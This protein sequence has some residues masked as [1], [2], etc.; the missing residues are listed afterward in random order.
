MWLGAYL[1]RKNEKKEKSRWIITIVLVRDRNKRQRIHGM[2]EMG[3]DGK[4]VMTGRCMDEKAGI[5]RKTTSPG[6]QAGKT[7][8][9][10]EGTTS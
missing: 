8:Q 6:W 5:K 2:N 7:R 3:M 10:T 1:L 4:S 9:Y